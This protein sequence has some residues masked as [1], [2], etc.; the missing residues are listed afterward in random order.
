MVK[1]DSDTIELDENYDSEIL[2]VKNPITKQWYY[3]IDQIKP[4]FTMKCSKC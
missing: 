4:Y 3:L 1:E 2:M